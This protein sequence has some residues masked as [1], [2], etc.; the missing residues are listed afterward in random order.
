MIVLVRILCT[1]T[2]NDCGFNSIVVIV[3]L[4]KHQH[5]GLSLYHNHNQI[6]KLVPC[7]A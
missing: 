2:T 3:S 4:S 1:I 5:H 6:Y 7:D